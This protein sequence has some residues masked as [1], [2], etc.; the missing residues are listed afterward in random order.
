MGISIERAYDFYK[1]EK[2]KGSYAVL[3]DRMWPRGIKKEQL[4]LDEWAKQLAPSTPLRKWFAHDINKWQE[5]L[6]RYHEEVGAY[7]DEL[8]RLKQLSRNHH[9]ILIYGAKDREHNQAIALKSLLE[10]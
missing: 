9:L 7:Q 10:Q 6:K 2:P 3:V 5:F 1:Q 4:Q 8:R